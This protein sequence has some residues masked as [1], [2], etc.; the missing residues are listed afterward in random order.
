[1]IKRISLSLLMVAFGFCFVSVVN[2]AESD[3]STIASLT[4]VI[5][6]ADEEIIQIADGSYKYYYKIQAIDDSDFN[7]YVKSKY[8]FDNGDE[9]SDQYVQAQSRVAEY[10][11]TFASLI[12]TLNTTADLNGWT[13]STDKN[14]APTG[15]KYEAGKHHGYVLAVAAVKDQTIY[16]T[17]LILEATSATT[18]ENIIYNASD[19][20]TTSSNTSNNGSQNNQS[21]KTTSNPETGIEDCAI[22]LVPVAI[23]LGSGILLKRNYA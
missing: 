19:E 18:L 11:D 9:N 17:R 1:M 7:T 20:T 13:E 8:I 15:L 12:P 23:I 5:G 21:T 3:L 6:D 10:E 2:A 4:S 14:I 22:Y 16:A